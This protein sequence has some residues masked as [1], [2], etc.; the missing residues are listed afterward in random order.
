[1]NSSSIVRTFI[2]NPHQW[3]VAAANGS[4][5][6][7]K[8]ALLDPL[9]TEVVEKMKITQDPVKF[10]KY[11]SRLRGNLQLAQAIE[12]PSLYLTIRAI[13]GKAI[14]QCTPFPQKPN[15]IKLQMAQDYIQ[16]PKDLPLEIQVTFPKEMHIQV[17][18]AGTKE[19]SLNTLFFKK[20][21]PTTSYRGMKLG[22]VTHLENQT[23]SKWVQA[24]PKLCLPFG[25]GWVK[26]FLPKNGVWGTP[27]ALREKFRSK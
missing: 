19:S 7:V 25:F 23:G 22:S 16:K 20:G 6:A 24:Y 2:Q 4:K 9:T 26:K 13:M 18:K 14:F 5:E 21:A 11:E 12:E 1:M 3:M 8:R 15:K 27:E 10:S 17:T